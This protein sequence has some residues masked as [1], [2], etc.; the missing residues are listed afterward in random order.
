MHC[1]DVNAQTTDSLFQKTDSLNAARD[2]SQLL[3]DNAAKNE[4]AINADAATNKHKGYEISGI[5]KDKNTGEG[6]PFAIISFPGTPVGAAADVDGNFLLTADKLPSDTLRAQAIGYA[7]ATKRLDPS[8]NTF[9]LIIELDRTETSLDEF[10]FHGGEDPA[11]VLLRNIIARKDENNPDRTQNYKYEVYNKLEVDLERLS[12]A[13]FE[14]LPVP[15]IK[16]FSFIYDN[17][18]TTSDEEPFLPMY[19][20]E[21]ISDYYFQ[22]SPKK[23]REFIRASQMKGIKNESIT[24]FLGSMYQNINSYDNFIPVFDKHFVSPISNQ[25]LF[26]YKYK[27][28]DTQEIY[29][30]PVIL[31]QFKPR[32]SGENCFY[33]D[34]WVVDS[35]Y[36]LQRVSMQVPKDANINW[37]SRVNLYQEFA[38]V[39]DSLWFC[40]KDKFIV[41][42]TLPYS[43]KLPGFIGRKTTSYRDVV[44]NHPSVEAILYDPKIKGDIIVADTARH[45]SDDF[46]ASARHDTLNKNERAIYRMLDTIESMPLFMR[47]KNAIKFMIT[48]KKDIGAFEIGPIWNTYSSNPIEGNRFRFSINTNPRLFKDIQLGG[49]MAYG[50]RDKAFKYRATAMWLLNR[51]PWT[52]L[53]GYISHDLDRSTSYYDQVGNDNLFS[54]T[55]RKPGVP[56]KISFVDE[57][58]LDWFKEYYFGFSHTLSLLHRD[59]TPYDPLPAQGIFADVGGLPS[60][61]IVNTEANVK[62]RF[63]YREKFVDGHYKRLSLGSKYPI[64]EMRYGIG[65][66]NIWN[67]GYDYQKLTLSISDRIRIAPLGSLHLNLYGG[68]YFGTLPYPL[69]EIHPGN[70]F[71]YY[72]RHAFNMMNRFEFISD[73]YAGINV[74]HSIGGGVFNYIPLLKRIKMRQ[75]WTAKVLYGNLSDANK[76]LNLDKGYPF[77]TLKESPYVELGT[78]VSNIFQL[79]RIDFIW[80]V[81]P[82]LLPE[83]GNERYFG[84]FASMKFDF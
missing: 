48:G 81:S 46:W 20:T 60:E 67:S 26:Y 53:Y 63:A 27:I 14:K 79:F 69:L 39:K 33:G 56:W 44:V 7:N 70:E 22:R 62:L 61:N 50:T 5:I 54:N 30:H 45:A 72:N 68:K 2:S 23:T 3:Q 74:E 73:Q 49:Y 17:L 12:K 21:T 43:S 41:D 13:Q 76:Q 71:Q 28:K 11:V 1:F 75:F 59:F 34:F 82:E 31:V 55:F 24:E 65:L 52:Y 8:K 80:R 42:F 18:D 37:V 16:Q 64:I 66:K 6:I 57:T 32:R 77:R 78:G 40:I 15:F 47:Y 29:G 35:I 58:R 83:E 4:I 19:L 51:N 36:A 25:G 10:V 84:I 38:P 9:H